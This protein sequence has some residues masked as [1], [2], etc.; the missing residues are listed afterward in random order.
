MEHQSDGIGSGGHSSTASS[1]EPWFGLDDLSQE[2]SYAI[3]LHALGCADPVATMQNG[4]V[5]FAM[6]SLLQLA[7]DGILKPLDPNTVD[8]WCG[9][10]GLADGEEGDGRSPTVRAGRLQKRSVW[11][12]GY[13]RK[14]MPRWL[15]VTD[16]QRA[17]HKN[18]PYGD[19]KTK[20]GN[21]W[22]D[23]EKEL[24]KL[25]RRGWVQPWKGKWPPGGELVIV[26]GIPV[27]RQWV[28]VGQ[29]PYNEALATYSCPALHHCKKK[30][31]SS[32]GL[33]FHLAHLRAKGQDPFPYIPLV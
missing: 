7:K 15:K 8:D 27:Y 11:Y 3:M 26:A 20:Q 21:Q 23:H 14:H 24:H 32:T 2:Q 22:S 5:K 16:E 25:V 28:S 31:H 12:L 1:P 13:K 10:A 18:S 17:T 4:M 19:W 29:P 6:G 9:I 30:R 33:V